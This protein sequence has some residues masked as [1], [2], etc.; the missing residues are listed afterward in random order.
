[1]N[2]K[3][4]K[5]PP[6]DLN[7]ESVVLG[8][9]LIEKDAILKVIK[10]FNP[11]IFYKEE[12]KLIAQSILSL[13]SLYKKIDIVTVISD[14]NK[15]GKLD[16]VGGPYYITELTDRVVSSSHIEDH[17]DIL[18]NHHIAREQIN[19]YQ[20]KISDLYSIQDPFN[21]AAEVSNKLV[22]LQEDIYS[23]NEY[24]MHD[25]AIESIKR[26]ETLG[27]EIIEFSGYSSGLR[28]LDKVLNGI[29]EPDLTIVAGRPGMAKTAFALNIAKSLAYQVPTALFSLEMGAS[30][31]YN[32]LLTNESE[33]SSIK[34]KKNDLNDVQ[35]QHLSYA[36]QNLGKLPLYINDTPALNIDKFRSLVMIL[37]R[38]HG[39]KAVLIDYIGLMKGNSKGNF[40]KTIEMTEITGKLKMIAK[41]F[42]VPIIALSQLSRDVESRKDDLFVPRLSDLRDSGSIEQDADN[43]IFLWRPEY[44][45]LDKPVYFSEYKMDIMPKNL[46]M[47][48]IAKCRD[49]ETKKVPTWVD[50]STMKIKDHPDIEHILTNPQGELPF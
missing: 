31:L 6:H 11:E 20:E 27:N 29:K 18:K 35:K 26:R 32:R 28:V 33:I 3:E 8:A 44:Y 4:I 45:E 16:Q 46:L 39:V 48:Y 43:V 7:L 1:M 42:K 36:D 14:L 37:K 13:H 49:G 47:L 15:R 23:D 9:I 22:M 21:I 17:I 40:Q 10:Q 50:L 34:I 24:S 25:L 5:L 41:E 2:K 19:L 30:Q 38:K 12:N